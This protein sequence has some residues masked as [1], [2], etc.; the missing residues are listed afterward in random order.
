MSLLRCPG[1]ASL[2]WGTPQEENGDEGGQKRNVESKTERKGAKSTMQRESESFSSAKA[3]GEDGDHPIA[4]SLGPAKKRRIT[5]E[6]NELPT[7]KKDEQR[8][9]DNKDA[10]AGSDSPPA[11]DDEVVDTDGHSVAENDEGSTTKDAEMENSAGDQAALTEDGSSSIVAFTPPG[12]EIVITGMATV[13]VLEARL[14]SWDAQSTAWMSA[15]AFKF[16]APT[17][18]GQAP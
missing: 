14:K 18:V 9:N 17:E 3:V 12:S 8:I 4:S 16:V 10:N 13:T 2:G 1:A 11:K 15:Q 6:K 5:E 7:N